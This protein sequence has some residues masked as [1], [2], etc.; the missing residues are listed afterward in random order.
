[1][2]TRPSLALEVIGRGAVSPAGCTVEALQTL[3]SLPTEKEALLSC[4]DETVPVRR[5]DLTQEAL[6]RCQQEPRLR[7]ASPL[8]LFLTEAAGQALAAA[9]DLPLTRVGLVCALSTGSIRYSRKFYADA[10]RQGRRFASPVLFP[11]TVYNSPVSHVAAALGLGGACYT[12]MGD[13]TAWVEALRVAR[14]WLTRGSVDAV[15]VAGGEEIDS[16]S[17]EAYRSS[18]WLR[19]EGRLAILPAEG[20]GA[21]LVRHPREESAEGIVIT[22]AARS[23]SFG[24]TAERLAAWEKATVSEDSL[25]LVLPAS[26]APPDLSG[27]IAIARTMER[28]SPDWGF[29]FTASTAWSFLQALNHRSVRGKPFRLL[30]PGSN[31]AVSSATFA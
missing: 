5:V 15:I 29:A 28:L 30:V 10:L 25:P 20:A 3:P 14:V 18:G 22:P 27:Q 12:L 7:R 1:M 17:L 16:I 13:E 2:K 9:P 19:G 26:I 6:K 21:V 31:A 23:F 8:A 24:T 4:P 11:E